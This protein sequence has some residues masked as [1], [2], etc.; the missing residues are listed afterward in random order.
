[1]TIANSTI[2][3]NSASM[4]N[5]AGSAIAFSG[6]LH[7][8]FGVDFQMSNST[9]SDNSVRAATLPGSTGVA[10]AR[11]GRRRAARHDREQ[12]HHRQHAA[13]CR[14]AAGDAFGAAGA[15]IF[16]GSISNS[17]VQDNRVHVS[18]PNGAASAWGGALMA[19]DTGMTL[20]NTKVSDNEAEAHGQTATAQGGGVY[21]SP[22]A[23]PPG[24]PLTLQNSSITG[25][26]L[27]GS[28][29]ATLQGGGVYSCGFTVTLDH[30]QVRNNRPDQIFAC[31][32]PLAPL[33]VGFSTRARASVRSRSR[34]GKRPEMRRLELIASAAVALDA[35]GSYPGSGNYEHIDGAIN[36]HQVALLD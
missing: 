4:T 10:G 23:G 19:D 26:E 17:L 29:G 30:S 36:G 22:D 11:L 6:G 35:A 31:P 9:I 32:N 27:S 1:M 5:T 13:A 18:S 2:S 24:G 14:S 8:D 7:V 3:G 21:D 15:S 28:T 34:S 12:P 20:R 33:G 16:F 25:N